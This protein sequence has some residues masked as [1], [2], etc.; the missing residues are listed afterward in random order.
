M[1]WRRDFASGAGTTTNS[2]G[3][4]WQ[5]NN[6][7]AGL[8][9]V[10]RDSD[11]EAGRKACVP[12]A[13]M[14]TNNDERSIEL[15]SSSR[16]TLPGRKTESGIFFLI[17]KIDLKIKSVRTNEVNTMCVLFYLSFVAYLRIRMSTQNNNHKTT[18]I[19]QNIKIML[20]AGVPSSQALPG[21]LITAP[22]SVCVPV[23]L[24]VLA[25]WIQNQKKNKK[26]RVKN[27][28][29]STCGLFMNVPHF[30]MCIGFRV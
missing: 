23:V 3:P 24:G 29:W 6:D 28:S 30:L 18:I 7:S 26:L 4:V 25:V 11:G 21:Y 8:R 9:P 15:M 12:K 5:R 19:K 10:R 22:P 2:C 20:I 1:A 27:N 17:K 14:R 13:V 16:Q